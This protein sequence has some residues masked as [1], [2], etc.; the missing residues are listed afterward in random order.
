[1]RLARYIFLA[2]FVGIPKRLHL[3]TWEE[4]IQQDR[5]PLWLAR[6]D[7][8]PISTVGAALYSEGRRQKELRR[9]DKNT[10]HHHLRQ[11]A[12]GTE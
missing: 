10:P 5:R 11:R 8:K 4:L 1:M 7:E 6:P 12:R 9:A 2:L 3:E